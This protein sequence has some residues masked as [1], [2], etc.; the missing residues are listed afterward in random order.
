MLPNI[1]CCAHCNYVR[2]KVFSSVFLQ[3]FKHCASQPPSRA[4]SL[5]CRGSPAF[6]TYDPSWRRYGRARVEGEPKFAANLLGVSGA[7]ARSGCGSA[8]PRDFCSG[9][10]SS[11][12][13]P[14]F[15]LRVAPASHLI[16]FPA[17]SY[18]AIGGVA[19]P[20]APAGHSW[21][22]AGDLVRRVRR[23]PKYFSSDPPQTYFSCSALTWPFQRR[24]ARSR[25]LAADPHWG[26]FYATGSA[27]GA[28]GA[29]YRPHWRRY[30]SHWRRSRATGAAPGPLA[31]LQSHWGGYISM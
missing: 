7:A 14:H 20:S 1:N 29:A 22:R 10:S 26:R 13:A 21:F 11:P 6:C 15:P 4:V 5:G 27:S 18:K 2:R 8:V 9:R 16:A 12:L 23:W 19:A 31:P 17:G 30:P 25:A 3:H 28:S 24:A